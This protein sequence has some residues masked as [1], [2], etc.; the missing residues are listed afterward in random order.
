MGEASQLPGITTQTLEDLVAQGL[1]KGADGAL[2][3]HGP[4]GFLPMLQCSCAVS[5]LVSTLLP[6]RTRTSLRHRLWCGL[7]VIG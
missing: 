1:E 6:T 5:R 2:L 4:G 7:I 3:L